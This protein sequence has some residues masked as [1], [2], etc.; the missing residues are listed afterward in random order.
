[1]RR[2]TTAS[3]EEGAAYQR[4]CIQSWRNAGG[5]VVSVNN[6]AE[7]ALLEQSFPDVEFVMSSAGQSGANPKGLPSISELLE[8]GCARPAGSVFAIT[9]SDV[10]FRG[11]SDVLQSIFTAGQGGCVYANRYEWAPTSSEPGLPYLYGYDL[12]VVE[13]TLVSP[14]EMADFC[15]GAPWWD[16]LFL[17]LLA[18]RDAPL[19]V[20]GSPVI[21][22]STHDQQWKFESWRHGLALVAK[23]I[24]RLTEEEGPAAALLGYIC[25]S[26]EEGAI[27]GFAMDRITSE[28]G[29]VLGTAMVGYI[30]E[31]SQQ[32]LWFENDDHSETLTPYGR[33]AV[34]F[35]QGSFEFTS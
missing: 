26:F 20:V 32:V 10:A 14:I 2:G 15:I 16:Y 24:R 17:Y 22:H 1:M 9:N 30:A 12:F 8:V 18:A 27:S 21:S 34:A 5:Q 25:R 23:R 31:I 7:I 4:A 29:T 6:A 33:G 35:H 11:D 3:E 13:N 19:T 28:L